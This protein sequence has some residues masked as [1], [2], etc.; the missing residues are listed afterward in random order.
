MRK[1]IIFKIIFL[2]SLSVLLFQCG[3]E[4]RSES[5]EK[6]SK[7]KDPKVE[8]RAEK[9]EDK[10]NDRVPVEVTSVKSGD[11]SDYILLSSN[12]ETEIMAD[13]YSRIQGIVEKIYKEEGQYV[14]KGE[15]MLS[16]E[17]DEYVLKE[18]QAKVE[19]KK[20]QNN[21][22]RMKAMHD[23]K[24]L[25]DEEFESTKFALESAQI[26]WDEAKLNLAYMQIE[27]PI[28]GRVGERTAKIGKRIQ[29][30]DKL[31][32]VVNTSEMISI[33]YVPEKNINQLKIKQ[34][35]VVSSDHLTGE[36]FEAWIKRISPIVDPS[37]GTF[38]VTIGVRNRD[39]LLRPGMF[40][41][42]NII[43]DTHKNVVLVPKTAIVYE[44][45][46]MNVF[47]V[48]DSVAYKIRLVPGFEDNE[49][50]E[51]TADLKTDDDIIIV[52][53]AGMK[54]E[55]P[56]NIVSRREKVLN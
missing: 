41:N 24:L 10:T 21:F 51:S 17:A 48:R 52:G 4:K 54:N 1:F 12:L 34:K 2:I 49:K 9:N 7:D 22:N 27:A 11:I 5:D 45:E 56:V 13:I 46:Y 43:V 35:A 42:V 20:Q 8:E 26:L 39:G 50:V 25:S 47:V 18:K 32:S 23:K 19:F 6:A 28:S 15:T 3:G 38:K 14:Q 31:F 29:P 53:Q 55:T 16:L 44:N 30:T 37:S 40:I 33:V 36:K